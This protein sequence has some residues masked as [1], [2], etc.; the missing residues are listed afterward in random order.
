MNVVGVSFGAYSSDSLDLNT[1]RTMDD[2]TIGSTIDGADY[3][4]GVIS[5]LAFYNKALTVDDVNM[6]HSNGFVEDITKIPTLKPFII[7]YYKLYI[8]FK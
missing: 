6:I 7:D 8:N 1:R 2:L 4:N 5:N 3:F